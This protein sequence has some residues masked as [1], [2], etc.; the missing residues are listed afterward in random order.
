MLPDA[1]STIGEELVRRLGDND[2]R[3]LRRVYET[4]AAVYEARV[5]AVGFAGR[6]CVLDAGCGFGQWTLAL[7]RVNDRVE[8]VDAS[9]DRLGVLERMAAAA[10]LGNIRTQRGRIESLPFEDEAF[11]AVFCYGVIFCADWK[12]ALAEFGRV[13]GPAGRLYV[14]GCGLG[15]YLHLWKN[16]PNAADDH[17]PRET[18]ALSFRN[19]L[20]YARSGRPPK[21]GH[22]IIEREEM[23][24]EMRRH[25]LT[26][27]DSGYEGT[28]SLNADAPP[29]Q[30]FFRGEYEG[31]PG[32][33]EIVA[34]KR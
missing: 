16:R 31:H 14:T 18:A 17:D 13:L 26:I 6:T 3:F 5:S 4:P 10:G 22:V 24:L 7:A 20:E 8:A 12:S 11:D 34:D 2:R 1:L 19:T 33:Y 15:W 25:G 27:V 28:I 21:H 29:P 30:P 32:G 9:P 23:E